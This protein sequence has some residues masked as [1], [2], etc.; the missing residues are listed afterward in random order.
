MSFPFR[1]RPG[2]LARLAAVA[3][4]TLL[5]VGCSMPFQSGPQPRTPTPGTP[6]PSS[7]DPALMPAYAKFYGQQ[8]Q[9]HA[10]GDSLECT[11]VTVPVDWAVP[12]GATLGLNVLRRKA[13]GSRIGSLLINPGGPGVAGADWLR[14]ASSLFGSALRDSFDLVGW[15]P[16]GTG[17]S[18]GIR[19]LSDSQLDTYFATDATP[20]TPTER[21]ADEAENQLL[22]QGCKVHAGA[23]F[24]HVDTLST[25]KDM[26]VLRAV[27][28]DRTLSYF[29][30]S[31]GTYLG[32][33]YAQTFPW[34][35]GRLVLDG[36][37]DPSLDSKGYIAGQA[38]GFD[39]A[40]SAYLTDCLH[41]DG[42]PWRG[43]PQ[44]ARSQLGALLDSAH[45]HPLRT[46]SGRELTQSLM[47]T[48]IAWG[49]YTV[50]LWKSLS[51][52]LTKAL[53]GDGT[54]LLQMADD[55]NERSATGKYGGTMQAYSPIFCLD[56]PETRTLD[57]IASDAADL[58]RRYPPLGSFIGWGAIGCLNWPAAPLLKPER[59]TA[60][61]AAPILVVGTTGDPATPYEWA[62]SLAS[63]LSS[64]RLL[65][66]VG[67][68][69]TAYLAE[70]SCIASDVEAYLVSGTLPAVG[71]VCH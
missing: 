33:W 3:A 46:S 36:A 5:V 57:Q 10:C 11:K 68:G 63:Q 18:D 37:V 48:G 4:A 66:R 47:A 40:V 25:V 1:A 32:A 2:A 64:G 43:T 70:S 27:V 58:G 71:T 17:D 62:Q 8:P 23:L 21:A 19:C 61:G 65:T 69:H 56:H 20:E 52:A 22:A 34:R 50:S 35:V 55:Y 26:D 12:G 9:W 44:D 31:Y 59:L 15:D 30:A 7:Q 60:P 14:Q 51:Q 24:G 39:R 54:A 28:G 53:Q 41:Q 38:M 67:S 16:R 42:C 13:A 49:M 6:P 29:G 45:D